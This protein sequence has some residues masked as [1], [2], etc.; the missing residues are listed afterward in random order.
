MNAYDRCDRCGAQAYVRVMFVNGELMFCGHH[1]D[2][3]QPSFTV[4]K[5]AVL[6]DTRQ[7]LVSSNA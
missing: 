3:H 7:T 5:Y 2:K 1:F 4:D 6:E